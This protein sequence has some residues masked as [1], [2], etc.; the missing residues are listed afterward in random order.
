MAS[1]N[2]QDAAMAR[3]PSRYANPAVV[4]LTAAIREHTTVMP[5][6]IRR[7]KAVWRANVRGRTGNGSPEAF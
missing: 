7:L 2:P 5:A 1:I 3:M 6:T 4:A